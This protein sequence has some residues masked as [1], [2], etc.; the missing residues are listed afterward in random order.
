MPFAETSGVRI[1]WDEAGAGTPILLVMGHRYS[2]ALWYPVMPALSAAHRVIRFDNRGTGQSAASRSATVAQFADDAVAVMDAAG[3]AQAHVFGVSMGGVIVQDLAMRHP[4]RVRSL[5]LGC[6]GILSADKP[7]MPAVLRGL[8]YL[9]RPVQAAILQ[10]RGGDSGYGRA[11]AADAIAVDMAAVANDVS[12]VRGQVVQAQ[13][14]ARYCTTREAVAALTMPALVLHG[15]ED[16]AV[17]IAWGE[18]LARTLP[19]GTFVRLEGAGHNFFIARLK[20]AMT[21]VLDFTRHVDQGR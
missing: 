9:P 12:T 4:D 1:H 15:D 13:A 3:V 20:E 7:R 14:L 17:P 21:A 16:R 18:E 19:N 6:T 2:S 5:I 10:R 8:Y 11:A